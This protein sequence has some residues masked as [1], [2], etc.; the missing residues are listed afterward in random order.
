[1]VGRP[2]AS[3]PPPFRWLGHSTVHL[4]GPPPVVVDPWRWRVKGLRADVVLVTHAHVDHC[5][6]EDLRKASH[7]GTLALGPAATG[8]Q[9][10]AVFGDRVRVCGW[11]LRKFFGNVTVR[12]LSRLTAK[13]VLDEMTRRKRKDHA[14]E[15]TLSN[16]RGTLYGLC[17][18][19]FRLKY[20]A[21]N[22][23]ADI[24][25]RRMPHDG[26]IVVVPPEKI[27]DVLSALEGTAIHRPVAC[28]LYAGLRR[29]EICWLT[30]A[31]VDL[32]TNAID[33]RKKTIDGFSWT[34]KNRKKR[35]VPIFPELRPYLLGPRQNAVWVF[36]APEGGAAVE[37]GSPHSPRSRPTPGK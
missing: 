23:I 2:S 22:P 15:K 33:I 8:D 32:E 17:Q 11:V 10:R 27:E 7:A 16:L 6:P 12:T 31:D 35:V 25:P 30:W 36:P 37:L 24:P 26:E 18:W 1:M 19:A 3:E 34:P 28:A 13:H 4:A 29:A 21:S 5:S 14:S 9:L 20:V